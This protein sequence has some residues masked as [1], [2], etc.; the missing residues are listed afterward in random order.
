MWTPRRCTWGRACS[1]D[2]L[3]RRRDSPWASSQ[4]SWRRPSRNIPPSTGSYLPVLP[5]YVTSGTCWTAGGSP[6]SRTTSHSPMPWLG[7]LSRGRHAKPGSCPTWRS[8]LRT[9]AISPGQPTWRLIPSPGRLGT[10][11]QRG[12]PRRDLCKSAL[13]V[14]GCSLAGRQAKLLSTFT[15]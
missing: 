7:C 10:R 9:S 13:R 6:S 2:Y 12:L 5:G 3:A 15:S 8:I 14:S 1:S 11:R 4:R